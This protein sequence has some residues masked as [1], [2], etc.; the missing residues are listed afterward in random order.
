MTGTAHTSLMRKIPELSDAARSRMHNLYR[1]LHANPELSMQEHRTAT[2]I[3]D[4]L[5]ARGVDVTR[6]GGTGVVGIL[7]NGSGP[8]VGF[9][10]DIDALP[11]AEETGLEY[12]STAVGHLPDG[13]TV[14]VMH[15]CGHDAH[16]AVAATLAEFLLEHTDLWS[17][18]VVLI[19]QPG[20]ETAEGALAMVQD[21]LWERVPRPEILFGQHI[22][23]LPAG[24]LYY[25]A[26]T[27]TAS[28]D[29]WNV[30]VHGQGSHASRPESGLDPIVLA[31]H[32]IVRLQSIVSREIDPRES[33]VITVGTIRGG[34]KENIIPATVD[35]T[36]NIRALNKTVREA[37][38][39]AVRR[40]LKAEAHAS[41][42][43]EPEITPY[44]TFPPCVNDP[45]ET[46]RLA[47]AFHAEFGEERVHQSPPFM[48]SED[49]A[50]LSNAIDIPSVYWL[51]GGS[52]P[53]SFKTGAS[54]PGN[55]SPRFEPV[56]EPT[57]TTAVRAA[58]T[59]IIR[60]M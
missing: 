15:A 50:H 4:R 5:V 39:S 57:L 9:R 20:E 36:L 42:A 55:H 17:G 2:V 16:T 59:A 45:A 22:G 18:T 12:A 48:G 40:V 35:F 37:V 21:K 53:E 34:S 32:M 31:A 54:I 7:R 30:T 26:G 6:C 10:A 46:Q 33:A 24:R 38:L 47:A 56:L 44:Y 43:P 58:A 1:D 49:F 25:A 14:P 60:R 11:M 27:V 28:A 13:S 8:A 41:D 52:P 19:F 29:S 51:F 23:P 3:E